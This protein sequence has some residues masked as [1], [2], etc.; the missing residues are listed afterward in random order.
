MNRVYEFYTATTLPIE[1]VTVMGMSAKPNSGNPIGMFGTGLKLAIAATMRMGGT[2]ELY[3]D[4]VEYMF[5]R[6]TREFRGT[7]HQQIMM[8]K[9]KGLLARWTYHELPFTTNYGRNLEAWQVYRELSSNTKDEL[10]EEHWVDSGWNDGQVKPTGTTMRVSC[11]GLEEVV[12]S[13]DV[14][15]TSDSEEHVVVSNY[16]MTVYDRPSQH[17]YYRGVRVHTF[18]NPARFTYDFKKD[19][20]SLTEDRSPSNVWYL[21]H[22]IQNLWMT[23]DIDVDY[24]T[25]ALSRA[26]GDIKTFEADDLDYD[27][28][29]FG[30]TQEFIEAARSLELE[31]FAAPR[32]AAFS[33]SYGSMLSS[34]TTRD[35]EISFTR[36]EWETILAALETCDEE[37]LAQK[38]RDVLD[39]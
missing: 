20:V 22:L 13:G 17:L 39:E 36:T 37:D 27:I 26:E 2:F 35:I 23:E 6:K 9:R 16:H 24:I 10:G 11:A 34:R 15:L 21:M 8:K 31:G 14:F 3:I 1:A 38:V 32:A 29:T 19:R 12:E 25:Q 33:A 28:S 5:Y 4:G 7:E 30:I 18:K